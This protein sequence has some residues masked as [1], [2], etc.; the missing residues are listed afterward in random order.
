[1]GHFLPGW[2]RIGSGSETLVKSR[3]NIRNW[4]K[5]INRLGKKF[6]IHK[7]DNFNCI[8]SFRLTKKLELLHKERKTVQIPEAAKGVVI[9]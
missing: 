3:I 7:R 8:S 2:I 5:R 6:W 9:N 4:A 1:V